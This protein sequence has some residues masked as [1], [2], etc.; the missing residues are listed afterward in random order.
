[1]GSQKN[2]RSIMSSERIKMLRTIKNNVLQHG[3]HIYIVEQGVC[4]RVA[5]TIGLSE[6]VGT[7]LVLAGAIYYDADEVKGILRSIRESLQLTAARDSRFTVDSLGSFT[8]RKV[9]A[10]WAKS[11]MLG[12]VD[13]YNAADFDACQIVPDEEHCTIDVPNLSAPWSASS[14]PI[15]QWLHEPWQYAVSATS[16]VA[17]N[18]EALRGARITQATRWEED[19]WEM[20]AGSD[21]VSQDDARIVPLGCLLAADPSLS[22]ALELEI[23]KRIRRSVEGGDWSRSN[24]N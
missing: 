7:E 9:H 22:P 6:S 1:M 2:S 10:S 18:L 12:T 20:F 8:L 11:L 16:N 14:E 3:F 23:G 19:Y 24:S 17:T 21:D 5:Y 4:P 13:Y 15:W